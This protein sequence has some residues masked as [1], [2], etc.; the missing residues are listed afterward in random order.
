MNIIENKTGVYCMER[1]KASLYCDVTKE[2][3]LKAKGYPVIGDTF[4]DWESFEDERLSTYKDRD[5]WSS[6][7]LEEWNDLPFYKPIK[8]DE[9]ITIDGRKKDKRNFWLKK[10]IVSNKGLKNRERVFVQVSFAVSKEK[11]GIYHIISKNNLVE[12]EFVP[13]NESKIFY[14]CLKSKGEKNE[15][16]MKNWVAY[17][18]KWN[19]KEDQIILLKRGW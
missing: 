19:I 11:N 16:D 18:K 13:F 8:C 4:A 14:W 1:C 7:V 9:W 5:W 10:I 17:Q 12:Y 15:D 3:K 2:I 6:K